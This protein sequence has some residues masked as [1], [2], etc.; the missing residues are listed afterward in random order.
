MAVPQYTGSVSVPALGFF[1]AATS[2]PG[3]FA[4]AV[5]TGP[6]PYGFVSIGDLNTSRSPSSGMVVI[7]GVNERAIFEY[8]LSAAHTTTLFGSGTSST[9]NL[10][11]NGTLQA[12]RSNSGVT[13]YLPP[14]YIAAGTATPST[15]H[16]VSDRVTASGASTTVT[17]QGPAAFSS[18][19]SYL[20]L[21]QD[22]SSS[23][24]ITPAQISGT[25]FSFTSVN[26]RTYFIFL[27]GT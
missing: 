25:S 6:N 27:I 26:G 22:V 3:S 8:G 2:V 23:A 13:S 7:G 24:L 4:G 1:S 20:C 18:A 14:T 17:L 10:V 11:V 19:V 21:V 5:T 15:I 16:I 9:S 12:A